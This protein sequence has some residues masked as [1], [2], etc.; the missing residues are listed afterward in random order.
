VTRVN[1]GPTSLKFARRR[2]RVGGIAAVIEI[3]VLGR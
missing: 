3:A 2:F 1:S